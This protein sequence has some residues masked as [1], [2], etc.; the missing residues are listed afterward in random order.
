MVLLRIAC[1]ILRGLPQLVLLLRLS[2]PRSFKYAADLLQLKEKVLYIYKGTLLK[3]QAEI[4]PSKMQLQNISQRRIIK[5][6][7]VRSQEM[8]TESL[9]YL[10]GSSQ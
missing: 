9:D 3:L 1:S 7:F 4:D 5:L 10:D 2:P 8:K 6:V